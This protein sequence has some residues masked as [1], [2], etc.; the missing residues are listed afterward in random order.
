MVSFA[1]GVLQNIGLYYILPALL[2]FAITFGI[3]SK[4]QPFG[5]NQWI[6]G[7]A[8]VVI[9]LLFASLIK[10]VEFTNIFIPL[11][12][13]FVLVILFILLI[14]RFIGF[15]EEAIAGALQKS[16]LGYG[17]IILIIIIFVVVALSVAAPELFAPAGE[18]VNETGVP[19]SEQMMQETMQ[20]LFNP[21][22]L[23]VIL[24]LIMFAVAIW[25]LTKT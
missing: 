13:G 8:S 22:V 18:E 3:L 24:L 23:G 14:F 15:G 21:A 19:T 17:I 7:L 5:D 4:Y 20:V 6:N 10:A 1:V 12:I 9:A 11:L 16:F 2:I 25:M